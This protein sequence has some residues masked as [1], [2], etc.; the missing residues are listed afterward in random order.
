LEVDIRQFFDRL[1]HQVL[2][3]L[4]QQRVRDGVVLRLLGKWLKAGVLE[5]GALSYPETG[6]PQGGVISPLLA[7]IYLHHVLDAWWSDEVGPRLRGPAQL[8]RYADDFVIV[9]AS[10]HDARRVAAV[11]PRRLARFGLEVH[12]DKTRLV[13][14]RPPRRTEGPSGNDLKP[15]TFDFLGFTHYWGRSRRG[16]PTVCRKTAAS[17]FRRACKRAHDWLRVNR[18]Q[19]VGWQHAQLTRKLQGHDAYYGIT[20]NY[21][22][23]HRLR[24]F[25]ERRWCYWLNRRSRGKPM[26]WPRFQRLLACYPLPAARVVQSVFGPAAKP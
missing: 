25:V 16:R 21:I 18:H 1:N 13:A 22:A 20:G 15:G 24:R 9:F 19:P 17:R 3:E 8:V 23:L 2:R 26:P 11:L 5:D 14:F 7:N 6:T 10:E 12:P 4:V